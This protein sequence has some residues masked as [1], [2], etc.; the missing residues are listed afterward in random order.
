MPQGGILL[1]LDHRFQTDRSLLRRTAIAEASILLIFLA[2]IFVVSP[3]IRWVGFLF[4][5]LGAGA[6]LSFHAKPRHSNRRALSACIRTKSRARRRPY[7][8]RNRSVRPSS[9]RV[10]PLHEEH[11]ED[12]GGGGSWPVLTLPECMF[13]PS[14]IWT[15]LSILA[16]HSRQSLSNWRWRSESA[17]T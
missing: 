9:S 15:M 6:A 4:S 17:R 10:Q 8:R 11:R 7:M 5:V 14:R 1:A 16:N 12:A 3:A 2:I 13:C